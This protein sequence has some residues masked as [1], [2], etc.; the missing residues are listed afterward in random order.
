LRRFSFSLAPMVLAVIRGAVAD[1]SFRRALA[2][3]HDKSA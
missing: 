1:E 2:V 3:F